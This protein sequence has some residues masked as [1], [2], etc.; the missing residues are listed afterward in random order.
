ME[1]TTRP[2][3][4]VIVALALLGGLATIAPAAGQNQATRSLR[5]VEAIDGSS[6]KLDGDIL[7]LAGIE[8]PLASDGRYAQ[9]WAE[10]S[11]QA[12]QALIAGKTLRLNF[13]EAGRDR[14][15]RLLAQATDEDG[16]W[17][18]GEM[19]RNGLARV[20]VASL[21]PD[22]LQDMLKL[23][24]DARL[25]RRGLWGDP[26]FTVLSA[27][28]IDRRHLDRFQLV[29][30]KVKAVATVRGLTFLNFGEDWR[31]DFTVEIDAAS[32]RALIKAGLDPA[33][34]KDKTIRV[35]GWP[36]WRNG[37][38]ID[39]KYPAQIEVLSD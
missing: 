14:Y 37:P 12:L 21:A 13:V 23:E 20:W 17:L 15:S 6:V 10:R 3:R 1:I 31:Q 29:E 25:G 34:L 5:A 4:C 11:R 30:G 33:R 22:R 8:V 38:A 16:V 24:N 28:A 26:F 9:G 36:T 7:R 19:L 32:R 18:Q 2:R 35:R 39:V 27:E